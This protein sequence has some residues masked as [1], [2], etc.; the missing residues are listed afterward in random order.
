MGTALGGGL[1]A[2][3][4][5]LLGRPGTRA[6]SGRRP[7]SRLPAHRRRSTKQR[8][9]WSGRATVPFTCTRT[10][11]STTRVRCSSNGARPEPRWPAVPST[12]R[13]LSSP[14]CCVDCGCRRPPVTPSDH[15]RTCVTSWWKPSPGRSRTGVHRSMVDWRGM[16]W[17]SSA[18]FPPESTRIGSPPGCSPAAY[19][20]HPT[21]PGSQTS[22]VGNRPADHA[23]TSTSMRTVGAPMWVRINERA[24]PPRTA[25]RRRSAPSP[26]APAAG[27]RSPRTRGSR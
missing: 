12:S 23:G 10:W 18:S 9:C 20:S 27:G 15:C 2:G 4:Y 25:P 8:V 16:A 22:P 3:W 21:G 7:E 6:G 11:P 13:T 26:S 5:D 14:R 1:R 17:A 24:S 19:W